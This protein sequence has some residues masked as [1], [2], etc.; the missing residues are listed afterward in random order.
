MFTCRR[1]RLWND[2]PD[3]IEAEVSE[4]RGWNDFRRTAGSLLVR[5][6]TILMMASMKKLLDILTAVIVSAVLLAI[7][8]LSG[9]GG[10]DESDDSAAGLIKQ[11]GSDDADAHIQAAWALTNM[12][13]EA[14]AP[15]AEALRGSNRILAE[16]AGTVLRNIGEPAV[17]VLTEALADKEFRWPHVAAA[18][19]VQIGPDARAAVDTL[20]LTLKEGDA[21][22]RALAA[23]TLGS[24]KLELTTVM[25][26]LLRALRDTDDNVCKTAADALGN[27]GE[28]AIESMI[29]ALGDSRIHRPRHI[30]LVLSRFGP[31]AR[32]GADALIAMLEE[33]DAG[34]RE[35]AVYTLAKIEAK[36]SAV[37]GALIGALSDAE[38]KVS[39]M[40][41]R[42]LGEIG[43]PAVEALIEALGGKEAR[44]PGYAALAL[45][46]IGPPARGATDR[47][48][49][50]LK[51]G[52][53]EARALAAFALGKVAAGEAKV[54]SAL[55]DALQNDPGSYTVQMDAAVALGRIAP[56][57]RTA[58]PALTEAMKHPHE[59]V[60][61]A[62][63]EA[64]ENIKSPTTRPITKP[65][66]HTGS[67]NH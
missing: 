46:I 41:A 58:I 36:T 53:E 23:E 17:D 7:P 43:E 26:A 13:T 8:C 29:A 2:L 27:L 3:P 47:L 33:G 4:F 25:P 28:P 55:T 39:E 42:A 31:A 65:H 19:L 21:E 9:C 1:K 61:M 6:A 5:R 34:E 64:L 11:L 52:D 22:A 15:L 37:V 45:S 12:K 56:P 62:A 44:G 30:A 24:V 51:T 57:A 66:T 35:A 54:I 32:K 59:A 10:G 67:C 48:L 60:R 38:G 49:V 50:M 20:L 18:A 16:R 40:A 14:I 63:A